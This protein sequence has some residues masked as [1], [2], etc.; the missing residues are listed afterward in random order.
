MVY[1]HI[2]FSYLTTIDAS[3]YSD[4]EQSPGDCNKARSITYLGEC[5]CDE[6]NSGA[7]SET[8]T[9]AAGYQER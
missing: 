9:P 4:A 7:T 2:G 5:S 3:K 6:S 8:H 1:R